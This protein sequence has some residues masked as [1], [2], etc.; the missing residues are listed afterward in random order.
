[1]DL[2]I[3]IFSPKIPNYRNNISVTSIIDLCF[4]IFSFLFRLLLSAVLKYCLISLNLFLDIRLNTSGTSTSFDISQFMSSLCS[5]WYPVSKKV[6]NG[7]FGLLHFSWAYMRVSWTINFWLSLLKKFKNIYLGK[8]EHKYGWSSSNYF[9]LFL[10]ETFWCSYISSM[11][12]S[13]EEQ[14]PLHWIISF[15]TCRLIT[16]M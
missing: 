9:V 7:N 11:I 12:S 15:T 3:E 10:E 1:M 6:P 4:N 2:S 5:L 13:L 14:F 8:S 16:W